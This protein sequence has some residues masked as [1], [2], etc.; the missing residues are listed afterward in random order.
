MLSVPPRRL[1]A[2][3]VA[4]NGARAVATWRWS[5]RRVQSGERD[6]SVSESWLR[7]P[8]IVFAAAVDA[9]GI[10]AGSASRS[11]TCLAMPIGIRIVPASRSL[12]VSTGFGCGGTERSALSG[13]IGGGSGASRSKSRYCSDSSTPRSPSVIVWCIFWITAALPPRRPS[14]TM[15]CHN[16][17]VRSNGSAT[18]ERRQ[19]EHL[20]QSCP[21][22]DRRCGARADRCR[23]R[24][25]RPTSAARGR[26][27]T[28]ARAGAAAGMA[29]AVRSIRRRNASKSGAWSSSITVPNVEER[30]GSFSSRHIKPS[31][32]L[33]ARSKYISGIPAR[34]GGQGA[35]AGRGSHRGERVERHRAQQL[36]HVGRRQPCAERRRVDQPECGVHSRLRGAGVE[37]RPAP[38]Q[39][40]GPQQR[41]TRLQLPHVL[42]VGSRWRERDRGNGP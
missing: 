16:G 42:L 3:L 27:P 9:S 33:I 2:S 18:I 20:A 34:L 1:A 25:R 29:S 7:T 21:A 5:E 8:R 26:R 37:R 14:T 30:C 39:L 17:R 41:I 4:R 11:R 28:A 12:I 15:N 36:H 13:S 22:W 6:A 31:A 40:L 38:P 23:S 19:V 10:A 35:D 24:G 32:S